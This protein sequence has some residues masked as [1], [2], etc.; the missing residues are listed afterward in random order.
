MN[1]GRSIG[2]YRSTVVSLSSSLRSIFCSSIL[3]YD[4]HERRKIDR[5][6]PLYRRESQS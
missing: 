3:D 2:L 4:Y 6:I 5:V 1:D